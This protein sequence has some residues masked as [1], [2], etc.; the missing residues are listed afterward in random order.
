[1]KLKFDDVIVG[2]E[3]PEKKFVVTEEAIKKY[4]EAV[5]DF[6]PIYEQEKIVPPAFAV[7]YAR[8]EELTDEELPDGTIHAKQEFEYHKPIHWGDVLTLRGTV[9]EKK[10]KRGLKFVTREVKVYDAS[11][12][13][14]V[15]STIRVIF[16]D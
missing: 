6:S 3:Y 2:K 15:V 11:D 12:D 8:W 16:P 14:V 1:M 5:E 10:E 7:V 9:K 4:L 13:L